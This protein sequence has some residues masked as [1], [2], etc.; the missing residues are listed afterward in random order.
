[1]QELPKLPQSRMYLRSAVWGFDTLL[2]E[3]LSGYGFRFH[4]IGIL[5]SLR[6]VQHALDAHDKELS[7]EH[8]IVISRWWKSTREWEAIPE[9]K[10]IKTSR[11]LILKQGAFESY[12]SS[13]EYSN[14]GEPII[15]EYELTYYVDEKRCD[16]ERDLRRAIEW[17]DKE[18][19]LIESELPARFQDTSEEEID[20]QF[21][22]DE[23]N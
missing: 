9:L 19:T 20:R 21:P 15:R 16:L 5:A 13:H 11:D 8:R 7:P 17:C 22:N 12:A 10:F 18:L 6:A 3:R 23:D 14:G 1:M 4:M 2:R